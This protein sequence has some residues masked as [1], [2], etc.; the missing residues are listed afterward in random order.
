MKLDFSQ[1]K[2][3]GID[4]KEFPL[5]REDW[6]WVITTL[7]NAIRNFSKKID[8]CDIARAIKNKE[9]IEVSQQSISDLKQLLQKD[10]E[11]GMLPFVTREMIIFIDQ[12]INGKKET[13][14]STVTS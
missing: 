7:S 12:Q 2:I 6:T 5:E 14:T 4:G 11:I 8:L 3:I 13:T 9:S 10:V 1:F